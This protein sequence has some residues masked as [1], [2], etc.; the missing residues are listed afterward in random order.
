MSFAKHFYQLA[1]RSA[2]TGFNKVQGFFFHVG[3]QKKFGFQDGELAVVPGTTEATP[4]VV[5]VSKVASVVGDE[6]SVESDALEVKSVLALDVL[7]E[8]SP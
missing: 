7:L 6:E 8:S 2:T 5:V 4:P 1:E 3:F